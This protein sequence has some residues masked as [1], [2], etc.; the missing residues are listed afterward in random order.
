MT[1]WRIIALALVLQVCGA[2][3][4]QGDG[5]GSLEAAYG[6]YDYRLERD[7]RLR[8]VERFHFAPEVEGLVNGQSGTIG[9]DLNYVLMTSPNHHRA[10]L[11]AVRYADRLKTTQAPGMKYSIDCY[12]DRAIRFQPDDTV[13]RELF[14]QYLGKSGH[15]QQARDQLGAA[16]QYAKDNAISHYNIGLIYFELK[17]YDH[18]LAQAQI[19]AADGYLRPELRTLLQG[20]GMWQ[21][22][23]A[24]AQAASAP[25]AAAASSSP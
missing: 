2:A 22:P 18:A 3:Q 21:D 17:D 15:V 7:G 14:A 19:A 23:P 9:D 1:R 4:A 11:A 12:F 20:V 8:V 24:T 10:L 13:V 5:C 16:S 25:A 6:P